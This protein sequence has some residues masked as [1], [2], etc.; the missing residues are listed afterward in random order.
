MGTM[1]EGRTPRSAPRGQTWRQR[2]TAVVFVGPTMAILLTFAVLPIFLAFITSFTDLNLKGLRDWSLIKFVGLGNYSRL[3]ADPRFLAAAGNTLFFVLIGVP[4]ILVCS[5]GAALMVNYGTSRLFNLYRALFFLPAI[6]N[7]VA[8]AFIWGFLYNTDSGLINLVLS[9]AGIQPVPWLDQPWMAKI[10]VIIVAV[11][12]GSGYNMLI[13]LAALQGIPQ[14]YYEAAEVDGANNLQRFF[15]IT[16]PSLRFATF[17]VTVTT[18]ISWIQ[19]FETPLVL[20]HGGPLDSTMSMALFIYQNG[21]ERNRLGYG[22]AASFLLFLVVVLVTAIQFK[23]RK[24]QFS[25]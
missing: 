20:T 23:V 13:F 25:V 12:Q 5:L 10:S 1:V 24:E 3:I 15:H 21:F 17:F 14:E 19:L 4:L 16:L 11:W 2:W 7:I 8:V 18:T 9:W 22:A 6:T